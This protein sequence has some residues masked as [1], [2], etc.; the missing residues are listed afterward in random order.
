M[1]NA[2][3]VEDEGLSPS[4]CAKCE[5]DGTDYIAVLETVPERVGGSNPPTRTKL[6]K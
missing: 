1:R 2:T 5:Y 4:E 3:N 6:K